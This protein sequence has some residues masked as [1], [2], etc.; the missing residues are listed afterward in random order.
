M[1]FLI[2]FLSFRDFFQKVYNIIIIYSF[3]GVHLVRKIIEDTI[4]KQQGFKLYFQEYPRIFS[5]TIIKVL[6]ND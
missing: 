6:I 4:H 1:Q 5:S 2:N 3:R